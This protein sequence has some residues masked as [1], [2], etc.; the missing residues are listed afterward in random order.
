MF[1]DALTTYACP[2]EWCKRKFRRSRKVAAEGA[3]EELRYIQAGD[4]WKKN[5]LALYPYEMIHDQPMSVEKGFIYANKMPK[6]DRDRRDSVLFEEIRKLHVQQF[7]ADYVIVT[8]P[9][10]FAF[11]R[12][13]LENI[14]KIEKYDR[15]KPEHAMIPI[16]R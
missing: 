4:F 11:I 10:K 9:E 2:L 12:E 5:R 7:E 15:T 1:C 16:L 13:Q 3:Q 6:E 8:T 14:L